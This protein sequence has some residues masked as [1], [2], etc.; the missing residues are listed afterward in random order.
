MMNTFTDYYAVL[1]VKS[2]ATSAE[3]K[4]AFKKLALQ[5]HPDLYK[6]ADANDRMAQILQAYR[7][8][9]NAEERR[10]Y[11]S[12]RLS[13]VISPSSAGVTQDTAYSRSTSP[14]GV[15][16][17]GTPGELSPNAR[18]DR[19]RRYAFPDFLP[20]RSVTVDL[21]DYTYELT[22]SEADVLQQDGLLRGTAREAQKR[23]FYCHRCHHRW[24]A[25]G[26]RGEGGDNSEETMCPLV[27]P[28]CYAS[29]WSEFLLLRCNHCCAIFESEQIR[30][31]S[32]LYT[33]GPES[34]KRQGAL[35]HPYELFPLCP[36]CGSS[37]WCPAEDRRVNMLQKQVG[38]YAALRRLLWIVGIMAVLLI[39][40]IFVMLR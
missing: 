24:S 27:C 14:S 19:Q 4:D 15:N 18:R 6:G 7:T 3:I 9:S 31:E 40:L 16:K 39:F 30:Y 32:E 21:V 28:H 26:E 35:C 37:H 1:G 8:L 23:H 29:D 11:D 34:R 5:Y 36:Y 17:K 13:H 25:S 22:S 38:T 10:R 2:S 33:Y 20:D 12:Q